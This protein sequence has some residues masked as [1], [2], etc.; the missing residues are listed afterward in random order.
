MAHV[1]APGAGTARWSWLLLSFARRELSSRYAGSAWGFAWSLLHPLAQLAIFA[2]VFTH[3]FRVG[4]PAG[5]P[6]TSYTAFV[7]LALWPWIMFSEGLTRAMGSISANAGLIRKVAFPHRLL[8]YS[9]ILACCAIRL[10]GFIAV[11]LT[12]RALGDPIALRGIA[13]ELVLVVA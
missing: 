11:L 9:A 4:V 8:V 2:F 1:A 3:V 6:D 12:L 13:A 7:A 5:Y 10:A